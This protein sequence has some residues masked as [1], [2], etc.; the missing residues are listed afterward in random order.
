MTR[1]LKIFETFK[2]LDFPTA[3]IMAF[4]GAWFLVFLVTV[5]FVKPKNKDVYR[6][7]GAIPLLHFMVFFFFN[8]TKGVFSLGFGRYVW[9]LIAAFIY[10]VAGLIVAR[11][12]KVIKHVVITGILVFVTFALSV[13]YISGIS[14]YSRFTNY[15]HMNYEQSMA[16]LID[17]IEGHYILSD[18]KHIDYDALRAEYIP[19]AAQADIT[20]D[21]IAYAQAVSR[22]C[23]EFHD[24]HLSA[25]VIDEGLRNE[26]IESMLGNDYG[27]SM[28]GAD[29]GSVVAILTDEDSAAYE[30]GIHNGTVITGWDGVDIDEALRNV[31]CVTPCWP[32]LAFP[33]SENEDLMRP[34]FLAGNGG[35]TVNVRFIDDDGNET[36]VTLQ[37]M[38]SSYGRYVAATAP[39]TAPVRTEFGYSKMVND[40]CGY[41]C[42][43]VEEYD[44]YGDIEAVLTDD[45]PAVREL[46]ISRIDQ[47]IDQGMDRL[48]IDAR[49]ND[50]GL[51]VVA[52]SVVTLF[53]TEQIRTNSGFRSGDEIVESR[54]WNWTVPADGR[55]SDIPVVLLVN[56]G[57]SS[58]GDILTY[59]LATCP[60]VTVMGLT[61]TGGCAQGVAQTALM[62]GGSIRVRYSIMATLDEEGNIYIDADENRVSSI[63]L[64]V[65]IPLDMNAINEIYGQETDYP[66]DYAVEWIDTLG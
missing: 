47:M 13:F 44:T 25:F 63:P 26:L 24:G 55:Y 12:E 59:D 35:D 8:Y 11:K 18:H 10:A 28:L 46:L 16:A 5:V 65:R 51:D 21:E 32:V 64:D 41:I 27:F 36:E 2:I 61:T 9:F 33:I 60:N 39:F 29:D 58:A 52:S 37:S 3:Y 62:S 17:E 48:I 1:I 38:G 42:I 7:V 23:Y 49:G 34:V 50:G 6:I 57:T 66:L 54:Y 40:H 19:L 53:T 43:P 14:H 4:T 15:S 45:Y 30:L 31:S 20:G 22:L 56:A